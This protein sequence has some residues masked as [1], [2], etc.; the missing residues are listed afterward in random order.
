MFV[1]IGADELRA[2]KTVRKTGDEDREEQQR[3]DSNLTEASTYGATTA[4]HPVDAD[5]GCA[6]SELFH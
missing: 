2:I 1:R 3:E 5:P 4:G 6:V